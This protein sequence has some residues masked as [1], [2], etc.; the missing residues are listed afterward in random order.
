MIR[1]VCFS[2]E[3]CLYHFTSQLD[4]GSHEHNDRIMCKHGDT[5]THL[6]IK[7]IEAVRKNTSEEPVEGI[8]HLFSPFDI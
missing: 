1:G 8:H 7:Q 5:G 3:Q 2:F 6:Y 4:H